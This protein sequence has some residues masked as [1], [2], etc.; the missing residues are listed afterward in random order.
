MARTTYIVGKHVR[1]RVDDAEVA[2]T[3]SR[4]WGFHVTAVTESDD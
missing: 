2:E 4:R 3:L 1:D